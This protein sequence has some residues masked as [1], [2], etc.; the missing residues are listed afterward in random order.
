MAPKASHLSN[1]YRTTLD[2][3]LVQFAAPAGDL[4]L[5]MPK[6]DKDSTRLRLAS[7]IT[8]ACPQSRYRF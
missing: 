1:A 2:T 4:V 8:L 5:E 7:L 6:P 3:T